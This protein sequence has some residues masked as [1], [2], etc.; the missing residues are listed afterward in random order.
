[1]ALAAFS[2]TL[3][4]EID[5]VELREQLLAVVEETIQPEYSGLWLRQPNR[6][7]PGQAARQTLLWPSTGSNEQE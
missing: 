3:R 6:Q 4:Q 2:S 1:M 5:L 7:L